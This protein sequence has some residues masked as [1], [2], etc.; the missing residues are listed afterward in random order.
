M[1]SVRKNS[2]EDLKGYLLANIAPPPRPIGPPLPLYALDAPCAIASEPPRY[3]FRFD[4]AILSALAILD[5]LPT[6]P[7]DALELAAAAALDALPPAPDALELAAAAAAAALPPEPAEALAL[8]AADALLPPPPADVETAVEAAA[9]ESPTSARN[10]FLF[11]TMPCETTRLMV[12]SAIK[13]KSTA[14]IT[15]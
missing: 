7:P 15:N 14:F 4:A 1:L 11:P 13:K 8:A 12:K 5:E 3:P 2:L 9:L 10:P 6:P